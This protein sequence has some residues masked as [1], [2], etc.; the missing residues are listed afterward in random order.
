MVLRRVVPRHIRG[1]IPP[2]GRSQPDG[3]NRGEPGA[4][5]G[6][7]RVQ[8]AAR[9]NGPAAIPAPR[10][11]PTQP[12]VG[13]AWTAGAGGIEAH[14]RQVQACHRCPLGRRTD[15]PEQPHHV[16]TR[17]PNSHLDPRLP[18]SLDPR[19]DSMSPSAN[20]SYDVFCVTLR[21]QSVSSSLIPVAYNIPVDLEPRTRARLLPQ[22]AMKT[23]YR[24]S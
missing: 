4:S 6:A 16:I 12:P 5:R 7:R 9:G 14:Q 24:V 2:P 18:M 17:I 11:V 22:G 3:R 10:P 13:P 20:C 15:S 8:R 1:T 21:P 19:Q 23:G